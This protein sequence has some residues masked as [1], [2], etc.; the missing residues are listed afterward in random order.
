MAENKTKPTG[1]SVAEYIAS[2]ANDEQRADC[3]A[4]MAML[5]AVTGHQ[6]KMWGPSMIGYG[7]IHYSYES[8]RTGDMF[9]A[10]F[11]IRGRGLVVYLMAQDAKQKALL[12]RLGKHSMSVSCL[13]LRKLADVDK[14]VLRQLVAN[15]VRDLKRRYGGRRAA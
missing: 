9:L 15:S 8:G 4:L 11:A 5:K 1:A 14:R 13:Y 10:G 12:A 3:R 7:S 2:R 6:P